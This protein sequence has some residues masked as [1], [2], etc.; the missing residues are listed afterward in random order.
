MLRVV[1]NHHWEL[2]IV[3]SK[4]M[5]VAIS[6]GMP[7]KL[8]QFSLF[9]VSLHI[10]ATSGTSKEGSPFVIVTSK[11]SYGIMFFVIWAFLPSEQS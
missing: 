8:A 6:Y 9:H 10:D 3:E 11:D 5:M 4:E 1:D 7:F 2:N